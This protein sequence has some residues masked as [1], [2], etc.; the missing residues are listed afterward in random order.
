MRAAEV[1][2]L[3][4]LQRAGLHHHGLLGSGV[5]GTVA[6][7]GDGTVA[8]VWSGR[9][10]TDLEAL[11]GFYDALY[12][13]RPTN[14]AV[15]MP[16][17]LEL[18]DVDG[19]FITVERRLTGD[20]VWVADGT[21]P[22][23]TSDYIDA[24]TEALAA[25]AAIP[26]EPVFRTLPMLPDEPP[27]NRNAPFETEL[28]VLATRRGARFEAP[29]RAALPDVDTMLANTVAALHGLPPATPRLVHGDLIAANVLA[30]G[31]HAT[32]ILDFGFLSTAGDPAFDAAIAA[33]CFDMWGPRAQAVERELDQAFVSAF[34]HDPYRYSVYRAAYALMT[35]CCFGTDMS[36]GHFGWCITLLKRS[37]VQDA[38]RA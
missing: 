2:A 27:L 22:T 30:S 1:E 31:G 13:A 34:D 10:L 19:T 11:R 28:A 33:S 18:R 35:A 32:A 29:L 25:L 37:D 16:H 23:L 24:M 6:D 20:P 17:I 4:A 26:G 7:L 8:K 38:V 9:A 15:A 21:S 3:A 5:E 36:E 14:V 12:T